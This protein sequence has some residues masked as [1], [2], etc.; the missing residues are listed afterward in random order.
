VLALIASPGAASAQV[1]L[2][3]LTADQG[4]TLLVALE[5]AAMSQAGRVPS[6]MDIALASGMRFDKRAR[7]RLCTRAQAGRGVCPKDSKAGFGRVAT[8]VTGFLN[9]GGEVEVAWSISA[10]LGE[11]SISG[12]AASIVLRTELLGA[13]RVAQLLE[14]A[15]GTSVPRSA[16][17]VGRVRRRSGR[18]GLELAFGRWPGGLSVPAPMTATP[19]RLDLALGAVRRVRRDFV[20]SIRVRTQSGYRTQRIPDHE[21]VGYDMLR[22]PRRCASWP[23]E[24]RLHFGSAIRRTA[25][26]VA[27]VADS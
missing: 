25:G 23:Y 2:D 13:D 20:R 9:P 6:A 3:P 12:D 4:T 7:A 24:L 5:G 1:T 26:Q 15:L 11:P 16:T 21:L 18:F 27:C 22:T 17:I 8:T 19:A 10:Y 14:P